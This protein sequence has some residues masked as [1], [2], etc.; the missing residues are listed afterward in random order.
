[1]K[2]EV[3]EALK[4]L[5][6]LLLLLTAACM[7]GGGQEKV[8]EKG[9]RLTGPPQDGDIVRINYIMRVEGEIVDTTFKD[10]AE[11]TSNPE[12]I[13]LLHP[14]GYEPLTFIVGSGHVNPELS[15][16]VKNMKVGEKVTVLIPPESF[17]GERREELVRLVPRFAT[18]PREEVMTKE[19]FQAMF[20]VEAEVGRSVA[21]P[22]WNSTVIEVSNNTVRLRHQPVNNSLIPVVGGNISV[23]FNESAV[24]ME[25]IPLLNV[26]FTPPQGGFITVIYANETHML[27]DYNNP[28]AGKS[29][30]T[31]VYLEEVSG[32][33]PWQESLD[34]AL[35]LSKQEGKPVF[36][37]FTNTSCVTC[38]RIELEALTHPFILALKD[39]FVW[40]RI[41]V[42]A[43]SEVAERYKAGELPLVLILKD[44]KE[45]RR[46]TTYLPPEQL[47]AELN[48][49]L[50][51]A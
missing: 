50:E 42:E 27:V 40:S 6:L 21:Y 10:V 43:E 2:K 13:K 22:Y 12:E 44:G 23:S 33:F 49:T 31:E 46:I 9:E 8:V 16:A 29:L 38:R 3:D 34:E 47:R 32:P 39:R 1:L 20:D 36:A 15:R 35:K 14:F 48:S 25:F 4:R 30:E 7:T 51:E 19:R 24:T 17:A 28:L 37:L 18:V 45:V 11:G 41:D 5:L 26:T